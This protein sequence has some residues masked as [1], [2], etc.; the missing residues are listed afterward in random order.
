VALQQGAVVVAEQGLLLLLLLVVVEQQVEAGAG[1]G[2]EVVGGQE[3]HQAEAQ[4]VQLQRTQQQQP[5]QQQQLRQ[6]LLL[7]GWL[8]VRLPTLIHWCCM[9]LKATCDCR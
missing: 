7:Q 1:L 9:M 5:R 8:A 2:V 6:V 4:Q 3:G